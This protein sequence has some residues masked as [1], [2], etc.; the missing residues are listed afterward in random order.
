MHYKNQQTYIHNNISRL[1]YNKVVAL[2]YLLFLLFFSAKL[3][4]RC[5]HLNKNY[6]W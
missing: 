2:K 3:P 1:I 5:K 6:R 4:E